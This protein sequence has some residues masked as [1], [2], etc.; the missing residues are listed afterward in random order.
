MEYAFTDAMVRR[1]LLTLTLQATEYLMKYTGDFHVLVEAQRILRDGEELTVGQLRAVLNTMRTDT[2]LRWAYVPPDGGVII[3][4]PA[5]KNPFAPSLGRRGRREGKRDPIWRNHLNFKIKLPYAMSRA[6]RSEVIHMVSPSRTECLYYPI[7]SHHQGQKVWGQ[8]Q[9]EF[10]VKMECSS[11][12]VQKH[13]LLLS[14]A[15]AEILVD[16]GVMRW[17]KWCP[18]LAA[19]RDNPARRAG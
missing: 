3:D 6:A 1:D 16:M 12:L 4:F 10:R 5:S 18:K 15:E 7:G 19:E 13:L 11:D 17:C 2:S 8:P 14:D 9:W